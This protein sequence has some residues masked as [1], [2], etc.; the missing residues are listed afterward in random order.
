MKAED[1]YLD[2]NPQRSKAPGQGV[3]GVL[4]E[5]KDRKSHQRVSKQ[6]PNWHK[7]HKVSQI[8]RVMP[9]SLKKGTT[10]GKEREGEKPPEISKLRID[11][12]FGLVFLFFLPVRFPADMMAMMGVLVQT[13]IRVSPG[14]G[15]L[16]SAIV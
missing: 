6:G 2:T 5:D 3:V 10:K 16:S 7:E 12:K 8:R 11:W 1:D 15:S 4:P 13:K 9:W 14:K